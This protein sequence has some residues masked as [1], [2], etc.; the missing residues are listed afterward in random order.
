M[1]DEKQIPEAQRELFV[2]LPEERPNVRIG[3]GT[4]SMVISGSNTRDRLAFI[5]MWVPPGDGPMPH[6]H[7]C[8]ETFY[9]V[10]GEVIVFCRETRA[11][12]TSGM[13]V[14]IPGWAPHAFYNLGES[15]A[16]LFCVVSPAGL[17]RQFLEIGP[18]VAGRDTPS[19]PVNEAQ[20]AD[21]M[22]KI[23]AIVEK[24]NGS[25]IPPDTFDHLMTPDE[26]KMVRDAQ[27]K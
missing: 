3:T 17:E 1:P 24:Y 5:D 2:S 27:P 22:K 25:L 6:T 20:K 8:E 15:P 4:Y 19:P 18:R 23:P 12:A 9:V 11:R 21:L 14:A 10:E 16:R 7:E 13:A 26:I